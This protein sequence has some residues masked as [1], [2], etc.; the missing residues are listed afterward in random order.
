MT[1]RL[2]YEDAYIKTFQAAVVERL[3]FNKRPAVVLDRTAFYPTG[4]GQ[5]FDRGTLDGVKVVD[6]VARADGAVIHVLAGDLPGD[7]VT[8]ELDWARR[9]DHMQHHTG[10]HI[11]SAA[12]W[13]A[14]EARTVGFHLG[15]ESVTIDLDRPHIAPAA[16]DTAEDLANQIVTQNLPVRIWFPTD[17]EMAS[18]ELRKEPTVEGKVRVVQIGAF[19][20]VACGGTHVAHTGEVGVVKVLKLD[21]RGEVTRVEFRCGG[22]ALLDYRQKNALVNKLAAELTVGHWEI[23]EAVARLRAEDKSLRA[24][25]NRAHARLLESEAGELL[26]A[27]AEHG[28]LRI[29]RR[30]SVDR[31]V[32]DLNQLA[33]R[34][35]RSPHTVALLGLA[36]DKAQLILARS[37]DLSHDMVPILKRALRVLGTERG[38]GRPGFASGGGVPANLEQVKAA[39]DE[40]ESAALAIDVD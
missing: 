37:D 20:V 33:S 14:A 19:D 10:Q 1:K 12:F 21:K 13:Q 34:L 8:G 35:A 11:L 38:G 4:G 6:V 36:G 31:Q 15:E 28:N 9:F 24:E 17:E 39:L 25:L 22:R 16:L 26:K 7:Q 29:V 40:A 2:Y 32:R 5:P 30:A 23:D 3:A 18:L 27:A